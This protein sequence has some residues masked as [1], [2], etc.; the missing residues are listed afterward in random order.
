MERSDA[1]PGNNILKGNGV[2]CATLP[3]DV[4]IQ[5]VKD[6]CANGTNDGAVLARE[7]SVRLQAAER[8]KAYIAEAMGALQEFAGHIS[9][10]DREEN[11]RLRGLIRWCYSVIEWDGR[12][13]DCPEKAAVEAIVR[14]GG[15]EAPIRC[16]IDVKDGKAEGGCED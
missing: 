5:A 11:E 3:N 2:D 14:E 9:R 12:V 7:L 8:E 15:A 6:R 16:H 10:T 1:Q 4:L 13:E